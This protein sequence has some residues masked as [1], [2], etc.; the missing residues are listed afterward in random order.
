M[1]KKLVL[2][3]LFISAFFI[4]A[5]IPEAKPEPICETQK[6][7]TEKKEITKP[8]FQLELTATYYT[9]GGMGRHGQYFKTASWLDWSTEKDSVL[10]YRIIAISQDLLQE[11]SGC[12]KYG[13]WVNIKGTG[14][15]ELDGKW[16]IQDCMHPDM[17]NRIDFLMPNGYQNRMG[18]FDIILTKLQNDDKQH[19]N[20]NE[21]SC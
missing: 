7:H 19:R 10:E 8:L 17:K 9:P 15:T 11:N 16:Q 5:N 13:D 20:N 1:I 18:R 2:L 6:T 14:Y 4:F 3:Y 12:L 21:G